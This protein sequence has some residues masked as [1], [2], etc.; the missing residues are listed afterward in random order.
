M[1]S[2]T[3]RVLATL[4]IGPTLVACSVLARDAS[5]ESPHTEG[6]PTFGQHAW[7]WADET[8]DEF[9]QNAERTSDW[10]GSPEFLTLDHPMTKRLQFWV[11]RM[12]EALRA[13]YPDKLRATPRPLVMVKKTEEANAWVSYLPISLDVRTRLPKRPAD[14]G[15][16]ASA[17][18]DAGADA[19]ADGG[20]P[21]PPQ[22]A[23]A[24]LLE[25]NGTIAAP[26]NPGF[27]RPHDAAMLR[28]LTSFFN[29]GFA[30]CRLTLEGEALVLGD[31]CERNRYL[32]ADEA[33]RFSYYA[34]AKYITFT[35]GYI[36]E[37]LDED[38]IVS[39]LGH[40]LGHYYRS[41]A[42]MPTD[43]VNYFYSLDDVHAHK[44]APDA[45]FIEQTAKAREKL[46]SSSWHVDWKDENK[47]MAERGLGFYTT[48]QEADEIALELISKVGVPPGAAVDKVLIML[49]GRE[50]GDEG[51]DWPTCSTLREQSF[52]DERGSTVS[53]PV[54]D[55]SNAHH[56][57]CFRVF[58]M[59]REIA[60]HRYPIAE[61]PRPPGY[62]SWSQLLA[63]LAVEVDPALSPP[64]FEP[65][66]PREADAGVTVDAG[67]D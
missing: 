62:M 19:D 7:L 61:R 2:S 23:A 12:D 49:K 65:R 58:N 39:T 67:G 42:N 32:R 59:T 40:E 66:E 36:L 38:R 60:A 15:G 13:Q 47:L 53:V 25:R 63:R 31:G 4:L 46:R 55:P 41:H 14:D 17:A 52:K 45:R 29:D 21:A 57:L 30:K 9:R 3:K 20:P 27:A 16:A 18:V 26:Y 54:G 1:R 43:V 28:E 50:G 24:A 35:T 11:D 56:N 10:D 37:L 5:Q 44:P 8:E 33:D 6:D 64:R 51:L 34:T 22:N 48:E